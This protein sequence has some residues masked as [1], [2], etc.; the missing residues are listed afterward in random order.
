MSSNNDLIIPGFNKDQI[1]SLR[2]EL[3]IQNSILVVQ[4]YGSIDTYNS[5]HFKQKIDL[6][7]KYGF[8]NIIFDCGGITY[9]SSTGIGVFVDLM[10]HATSHG[11]NIYLTNVK[12]KVLEVFE[13][14]GFSNFLNFVSTVE[15]ALSKIEHPSDAISIF[16]EKFSCPICDKKLIAKKS[17]KFKCPNCKTIIQID[18]IG[19]VSLV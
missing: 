11:G 1:D 2:V 6:C 19:K 7:L 17:G 10:K 4:C 18:N 9:V 3:Y 14:L 13:L 15:I 5:S 16:P 8:N 12:S